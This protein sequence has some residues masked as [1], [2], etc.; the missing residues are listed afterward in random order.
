LAVEDDDQI[1]NDEQ[2]EDEQLEPTVVR[3]ET[4]EWL[5]WF[6]HLVHHGRRRLAA[7]SL[8]LVVGF[9]SSIIAMYLFAQ[10]ADQVMD[11]DTIRID[12]SVLIGLQRVGSPELDLVARRVTLLGSEGLA[13]VMIVLLVIFGVRRRW[14]AAIALVLTTAGA[15]I[16]NEIL[17]DLFRR[18]RPAPVE[19]IFPAQ[20]F[21]FPSGHA[22]VSAS[23]YLFLAYV[24]W[25]VLHGWPRILAV[26]GLLTL[27]GVIGLTR[28]YLGVHFFTDVVAGYLAG[29]AW[30][31][32]VIVGGRLLAPDWPHGPAEFPD[33]QR[34]LTR[35]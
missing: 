14:G 26:A 22:M 33:R 9:L 6:D 28:L 2:L 17:K 32:A 1:K 8:T 7:L 21:S 23:F 29:L 31:A 18:T 20:E 3:G 5:A 25:R 24:S 34:Q 12:N 4:R 19:F 13:V 30:T 10:I 16:L 35:E 11:R 27:I 15:Q